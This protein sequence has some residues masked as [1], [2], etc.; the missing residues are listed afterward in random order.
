MA[1]VLSGK[2]PAA[3]DME[4]QIERPD[5]TRVTVLEAMKI[6]RADPSTAHIP[7]IALSANALPRDIEKGLKAGFFSYIT[8]PIK[9]NEFMDALDTA[10]NFSK[11][12]SG[13]AAK[14]EHA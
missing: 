3:R 8:K 6:L 11:T 5:G 7:I 10:L 12:A 1:E 2:I 13:R 9:I 4:V 14:K